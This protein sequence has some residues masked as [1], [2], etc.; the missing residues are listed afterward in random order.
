M[1]KATLIFIFGGIIG[2]VFGILLGALGGFIGGCAFWEWSNE[3][4]TEKQRMKYRN[5]TRP[6][7]I[8]EPSKG[9]GE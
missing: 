1:F 4:Y 7:S 6:A 9:K 2:L 3:R 5:M 8:P